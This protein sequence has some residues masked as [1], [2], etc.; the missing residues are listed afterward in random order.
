MVFGIP[1]KDIATQAIEHYEKSL[2]LWKDDDPGIAEV[3]DAR[4]RLAGLK[5]EA[6]EPPISPI[7]PRMWRIIFPLIRKIKSEHMEYREIF[8][9]NDIYLY[10]NCYSESLGLT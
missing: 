8:T 2:A 5:G 7:E 9:F 1:H 4:K 10:F 6:S 3:E